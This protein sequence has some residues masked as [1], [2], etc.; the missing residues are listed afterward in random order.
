M[1]SM[2]SYPPVEQTGCEADHS[3]AS[4]IKVKKQ[5]SYN[6]TCPICL[7]DMGRDNFT[8]TSLSVF[9]TGTLQTPSLNVLSY[10]RFD[11]KMYS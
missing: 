8:F 9:M 4:D 7:L 1:G 5:W 3:P 6:S 11:C 10:K 2:S